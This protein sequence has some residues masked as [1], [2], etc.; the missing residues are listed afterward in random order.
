LD[1]CRTDVCRT[2]EVSGDCDCVWGGGFGGEVRGGDWSP[3][4][5]GGRG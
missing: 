3:S 4:Q 1:V 5:K 2:Q